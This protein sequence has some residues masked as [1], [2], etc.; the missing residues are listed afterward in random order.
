MGFN[1]GSVFLMVGIVSCL[2][3]VAHA[4]QGNAVYYNPPYSPS[5]CFGNRNKGALV[6]GVSDALWNG[7]AACG[8]RYRVSCVRG[9]ED[10]MVGGKAV[11]KPS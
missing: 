10:L 6:A 8:R 4:A 7:G 9:F 11:S 1:I 3:S 2:V 5:S